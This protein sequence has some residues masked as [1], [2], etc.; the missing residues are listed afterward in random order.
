MHRA[1]TTL[2]CKEAKL[3]NGLRVIAEVN[4]EAKSLALG[5]FVKTGS[6]DEAPAESGISH[7]LEHMVFKGTLR[8]DALEVNLE[9]DRM[10]AQYNAFTSEENTVY[11]AAVLPEFGGRLWSCSP[12]SCAQHCAKK[13]SIR[14][15]T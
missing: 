6:R 9:F 13:T 12:T 10:G 14:K 15:R 3:P 8:R 5:Y 7:F 2:A 11:Y 1:A 4:P